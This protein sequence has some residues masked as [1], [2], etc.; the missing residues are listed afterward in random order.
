MAMTP[1]ARW[2]TLAACL[3]L[4]GAGS[5]GAILWQA[6]TFDAVFADLQKKLTDEGARQGVIV[7]AEE[8]GRSWRTREVSVRF[9]AP[10]LELRWQGEAR[11]GLGTTADLK[12]DTAYGTAADFEAM[13]IA[14]Y[15]DR[16]TIESTL[17]GKDFAWRW[18]AKPFRILEEK[19]TLADVGAMSLAGTSAMTAVRFELAGVTAGDAAETLTLG[20]L[21][22]DFK[23]D[24]NDMRN[25]SVAWTL[26]NFAYDGGEEKVALGE[27]SV[28][29]GVAVKDKEEKAEEKAGG[30]AETLFRLDYGMKLGALDEAGERLW[31]AWEAK[32]AVDRV[33]EKLLTTL[34]FHKPEERFGLLAYIQYAFHRQGLTIEVPVNEWRLGDERASFTGRLVD[35]EK[36]LGDFLV[37]IDPGFAEKIPELK[38]ETEAWK[39]EGLLVEEE[40][41]LIGR[42]LID[43]QARFFMNGKPL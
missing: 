28:T 30:Q 35:T 1:A 10:G 12:L 31:D 8:T 27:S 18:D 41:R 17:T 33:P 4:A 23:A 2:G 36:G 7:V 25:S 14:G 43:S 24:A 34:A 20:R 9:G 32:A 40:G 29:M 5:A 16:I 11:F 3:V 22:G 26:A 19:R 15:E 21:T 42:G 6:S 37:A 39:K 13:G 38:Q